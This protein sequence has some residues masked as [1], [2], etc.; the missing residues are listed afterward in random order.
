MLDIFDEACLFGANDV[1]VATLLELMLKRCWSL[2]QFLC[3]V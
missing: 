3:Y 2:V 1:V